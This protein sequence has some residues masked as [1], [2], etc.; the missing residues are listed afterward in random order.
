MDD[1]K[2][3]F[4][5]K[6]DFYYQQSLIYLLTLILYAGAR[7]TMSEKGLWVVVHDPVLYFIGIFVLISL[8]ML[9]L[10]RIRDRKLI[11]RENEF[12]FHNR[13]HEVTVRFND[14]ESMRVGVERLVQ[15]SG[16]FQVVVIKL[17]HRRRTL[18]IR[19]GRYER[20][21]ELI[22]EMQRIASRF[23]RTKKRRFRLQ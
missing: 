14:V 7:G 3:T 10:N 2:K 23:P 19:V 17:K 11:V 16:R 12:V 18:R 20:E 13:F 22:A 1:E 4:R 6:L 8:I 21:K 9:I 5:Y 15:T